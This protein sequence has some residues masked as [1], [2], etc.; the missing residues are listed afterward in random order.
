MAVR[1][2]LLE[3][4]CCYVMLCD[5]AIRWLLSKVVADQC[6]SLC[7]FGIGVAVFAALRSVWQSLLLWDRCGSLCCF[8][9]VGLSAFTYPAF[10]TGV[11][12]CCNAHQHACCLLLCCFL[13][14]R[15][16]P[17]CKLAAFYSP[18]AAA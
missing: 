10:V 12:T 2:S 16:I 1:W 9:S 8:G 6:G 14:Q 5:A 4:T 17:G 3:P 13:A 7:C 15:L 11:W 18:F